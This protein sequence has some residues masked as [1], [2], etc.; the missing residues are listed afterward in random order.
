MCT[1]PYTILLVD[2]ETAVR[3]GIRTRTPWERYNFCVVGEAGNG[4]EA[5]ELIEEL[6]PD[7]V[8]TDIRMPY[9]DG[10]ELIQKIRVSHPTT[11]LVI[12]SGYDEFTYAQQAMR[13]D[14]SE[15]VLKPVSVEDLCNLLKRLGK[16][17]DEEIKRI[18]DQDRLNQAYQQALPLIREKFLVSLLTAVHPSSD[19]ALTAK[20]AEYGF[21]LSKDEFLVAVIETDHVMEDPLQSMAMFEIVEQVL[22]KDEG[23][24]L[25]QFE[26]QIVIIFSS[27]SHGQDH[28]DS[29]FRK[30]TYRRAEQ[31]LAYLQKYSFQAVLGMGNLVHSPSAIKMSYSQALTALNYSSC[32]PEQSLLFISDLEKL[33][34]E[35]HQ[36]QLEEL[37]A[38]V[39]VAV[40]LGSE[41]Q[42]TEALNQLL[43]EQLASL[44]LHQ[45]QALLLE[46]AFVLQDLTHAYGHTLFS[47]AE[48]EGRN[49]FSELSTLSTLGKAKRYFTRL[50]LA[51]RLLIAG[52]REQSHIQFIGQAK[53]LI[54]K[55]FTEPG[56]GLE[57][58]CEMIGVSPSY[59]SS[60][61]K[62]E[63]GS[64]FVQY[65]TGLRMD[66]AKELLTKTEG[67][68]Y[69]IAQSVGFAE[70]NYFSFC[71]KR[72]VGLS[73][74][75]FRQ[76]SR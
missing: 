33:P 63:V 1:M 56:F 14:V 30:Q 58:I 73:P 6:H 35:E 12:L 20:A 7:V 72:H 34:I 19:A 26:N 8:V 42:V 18:Q 5:L 64:S 9:M 50:C 16:H 32:Y 47:M 76:G 10:I 53:S 69:E 21:N 45:M 38:N 39:L 59:F 11:T 55:H 75:Q 70:P 51:V 48:E 25:F 62:K 29:V 27:H 28:Y 54:A 3:E 13:Y 23:G 74:S 17:L 22:K 36:Q 49:L 52:Q 57:E 44:S 46:L 37:K 41:E 31:L 40:K 71:F 67:K 66:R 61:F 60:T 2:D 68:T 4:I 65:L 24:L 15:Y 43:G